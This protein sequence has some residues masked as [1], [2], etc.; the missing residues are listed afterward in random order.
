MCLEKLQG[1]VCVPLYL[2]GEEGEGL[3]SL[4]V[5]GK[6]QAGLIQ[7]PSQAPWLCLKGS[8]VPCVN[9]VSTVLLMTW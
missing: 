7:G 9:R 1:L 6:T 3:A 8:S 2:D 5:G 4:S